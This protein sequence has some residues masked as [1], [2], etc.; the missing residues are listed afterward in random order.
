MGVEPSGQMTRQ[1]MLGGRLPSQLYTDAQHY[2]VKRCRVEVFRGRLE[3]CHQ[4]C[5]LDRVQ[6]A[7]W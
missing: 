7:G 5:P 4:H 1:S 2:L 6:R 3:N